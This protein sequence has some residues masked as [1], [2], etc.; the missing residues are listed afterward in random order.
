[1]GERRTLLLKG[2]PGE[3]AVGGLSF[4]YHHPVR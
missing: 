1:M 4:R 3:L 2:T